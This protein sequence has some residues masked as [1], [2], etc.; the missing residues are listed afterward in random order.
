MGAPQHFEAQLHVSK[1]GIRGGRCVSCHSSVGPPLEAREVS[2]SPPPAR[3]CNMSLEGET[4]KPAAPLS[5][6]PAVL[7]GQGGQIRGGVILQVS[8]ERA[9]ASL[10]GCGR[11]WMMFP[12]NSCRSC[13][14]CLPLTTDTS[15]SGATQSKFGMM[16]ACIPQVLWGLGRHRRCV[17]SFRRGREGLVSGGG[18]AVAKHHAF[19]FIK[20]WTL[21][22][23]MFV[24]M[25]L[26]GGVLP[27]R[28][29][30]STEWR[31]RISGKVESV[32]GGLG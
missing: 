16:S 10:E 20:Q 27:W 9:A 3:C 11:G 32:G 28:G 13:F 6:M 7:G 14:R 1:E 2:T 21:C 5:C 24:W 31:S 18:G 25:V 22:G 29:L 8:A 4:T 19:A 17:N 12:C 15:H 23:I 26:W 30:R